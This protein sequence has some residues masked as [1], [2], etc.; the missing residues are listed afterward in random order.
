[1]GASERGS[2]SGN[3]KPGVTDDP[4]HLEAV[5]FEDDPKQAADAGRV[6]PEVAK[7]AAQRA[8]HIDDETNKRLKGLI[9][10]RV[11]LIMIGTY[12]LQAL[13]KG[14]IS[15]VA[16]MGLREDTNLVGQQVSNYT[17]NET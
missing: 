8:V 2:V 9:D 15:F 10:K 11:L 4:K 16:I 6:D 3:T 14:T 13:D 5:M 1:M 17:L 12:F 7:Y